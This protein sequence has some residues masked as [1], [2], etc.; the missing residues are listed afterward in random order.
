MLVTLTVGL[1]E[2]VA[3]TECGACALASQAMLASETML[4]CGS[5]TRKSVLVVAFIK[6]AKG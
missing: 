1:V 2:Y 5:D 4:G 3:L 6:S